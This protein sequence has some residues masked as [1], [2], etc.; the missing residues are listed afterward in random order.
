[1]KDVPDTVKMADGR[2][3]QSTHVLHTKYSLQQFTD[4]ETFHLLDLPE[5]DVVL[6]QPW[7]RRVNPSID[8]KYETVTLKRHG[9]KYIIH[10]QGDE[11]GQRIA[12]FLMNA[13]EVKQALKRGDQMFM[14]TLKQILDSE[15]NP[16]DAPLAQEDDR[17]KHVYA[18]IV[19]EFPETVPANTEWM[20]EFPPERDIAHKIE[21][22][23]GK[24]LP[25]KPMYRMSQ[26]ELEEV[27]SDDIL[28][29]ITEYSNWQCANDYQPAHSSIVLFRTVQVLTSNLIQPSFNN[30]QN[31]F[32]KVDKYGKF[33]AD[34]CDCSEGCAWILIGS[35]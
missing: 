14:V 10:Q 25:N 32:S 29:Q 13:L 7:L 18:D 19:G 6:G 20:P 5:Y 22:I 26:P 30:S 31:V 24:P 34:L 27:I 35:K 17:W 8:W 2:T 11:A 21:L 1:M 23:P 33:S 3:V 28:T 4:S 9:K 15:G 16:V 12:S